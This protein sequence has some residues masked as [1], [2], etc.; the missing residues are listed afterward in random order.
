MFEH[1]IGITEKAIRDLVEGGSIKR[2]SVTCIRFNNKWALVMTVNHFGGDVEYIM[3]SQREK[4]RLF[5]TLEAA[6]NACDFT[7]GMTV[8]GK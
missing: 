2:C 5:A 7:G 3:S 6:R 8:I 4:V 1:M